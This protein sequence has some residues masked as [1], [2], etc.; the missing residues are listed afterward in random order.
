MTTKKLF[1]DSK[2]EFCAKLSTTT[3]SNWFQE[4]L[5]YAD[6]AMMEHG[7]ISAEFA[8][9]ARAFKIAL[10]DL[11]VKAEDAPKSITPQFIKLIPNEKR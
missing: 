2:P 9:G 11:A 1:Q 8:A 10:L 5:V 7:N 3:K 4:C 6:S